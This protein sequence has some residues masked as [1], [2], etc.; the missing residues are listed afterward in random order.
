MSYQTTEH[1]Q[2]HQITD[3]WDYRAE[4]YSQDNQ[5]E[6]AGDKSAAWASLILSK[7]PKLDKP[8]KVLDVGTG[9]GFFAILMAKHGHQ[10]TA[11]DA[12]ENM[13]AQARDNAYQHGVSI[14]FVQQDVQNLP[15]SDNTFDLIISRNVTWNLNQPEQAY[16]EWLRVLKPEGRLLNFDA[17]WYLYLFDEKHH[18]GFYQDRDNATQAQIDDIYRNPKTKIMEDIARTLPLSR[19]LRPRWDMDA[20]L[21][22]GAR[23]VEIN[24][25][26]TPMVWDE[27]EKI[28]YAS[29]PMFMICAHK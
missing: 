11:V 13:L 18:Q 3:Y 22:V 6:L 14:E 21:R 20:L 27:E 12:T 19:E 10:V 2:L 9:P 23:F 29:T 5:K 15:F 8:L 25:D 28:N 24:P 7:T 26:I 16:A 1:D 17:N 4:S